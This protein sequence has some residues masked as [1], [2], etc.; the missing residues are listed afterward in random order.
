VGYSFVQRPE[1]VTLL[2][3]TLDRLEAPKDLGVVLKV[4]T[5]LAVRN[6][7]NLLAAA[8]GRRPVGVMIARGDLAAEI[9]WLRLS[10]IQEELLWLCEAAHVPVIWATQVL[11]SLVKEGVPTRA[12]LSDATLAARAEC[13]MVN[14][15]SSRDFC[16]F[17]F[18]GPKR[19]HVQ[20]TPE[21]PVLTVFP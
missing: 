14:K 9:G 8:V 10:E 2:L 11:E 15:G 3:K 21:S 7:P 19:A 16:G 17:L 1:D 6:L 18:R 20:V 5:R 12:E 4:E 13:V